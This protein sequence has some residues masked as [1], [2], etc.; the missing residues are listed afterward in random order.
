MSGLGCLGGGG[1]CVISVY[2]G[3]REITFVQVHARL[4]GRRW[5]QELVEASERDEKAPQNRT[6]FE[7]RAKRQI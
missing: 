7:S 1:E 5:W 4:P 6:G 2:L 3:D